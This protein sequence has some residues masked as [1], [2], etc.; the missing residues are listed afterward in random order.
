[1]Q[2]LTIANFFKTNHRISNFPSIFT[3]VSSS[4][5]KLRL[6]VFPTSMIFFNQITYFNNISSIAFTLHKN[7]FLKE[8]TNKLYKFNRRS[9][10]MVNIS[11]NQHVRAIFQSDKYQ[12]LLI[13]NYRSDIPIR[14][15]KIIAQKIQSSENQHTIIALKKYN[16]TQGESKSCILFSINGK[17]NTKKSAKTN[18]FQTNQLS[19]FT[20]GES[21][22]CI[23]FSIHGRN[24][25]KKSTKT[26]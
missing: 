1:M 12:N 22:S 6:F 24:N 19:T 25:M 16:F 4:S 2:K 7:D 9:K 23:L 10:T 11:L 15:I 18:L 5:F 26:N 13:I 8:E 14:G 21:K 3:P 20:Q 17:I